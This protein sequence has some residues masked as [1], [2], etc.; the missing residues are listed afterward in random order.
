[1]I[2]MTSSKVIIIENNTHS[3]G[4]II[5]Y[6]FRVFVLAPMFFFSPQSLALEFSFDAQNREAIQ[7]F[8]NDVRESKLDYLENEEALK[9]A[10]NIAKEEG[11]IHFMLK[12]P[13]FIRSFFLGK[14]NTAI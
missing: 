14:K 6:F 4:L 1:V 7:Q 9:K 13:R 5:R 10:F 8:I 2:K 12:Q 11:G 3:R